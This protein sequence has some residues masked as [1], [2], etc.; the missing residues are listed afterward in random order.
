[1]FCRCCCDIV[2]FVVWGVYVVVVVG[3]FMYVFLI[4]SSTGKAKPEG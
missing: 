1:M 2:V 4:E 3:W